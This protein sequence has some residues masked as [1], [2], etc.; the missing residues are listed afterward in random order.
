MAVADRAIATE[1]PA[2]E[3]GAWAWALQRLTAVLVGV[4]LGVHIWVLHFGRSTSGPVSFD[5]VRQRLSGPGYQVLD[6]LLLA[7]VIY[8][9]LNGIRAILL[10]FGVGV[11]SQ[12][13]MTA[14]LAVIGVV[15]FI[16]GVFGL[17]P[18]ITGRPLF[19]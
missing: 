3:T 16:Y 13:K 19:S 10:D 17:V 9:A 15:G 7:T 12:G 14:V 2:R 8:H 4:F 1:A 11:R 5:S 6:M 18:F